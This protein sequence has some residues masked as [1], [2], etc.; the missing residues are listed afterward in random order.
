MSVLCYT[1]HAQYIQTPFTYL[2]FDDHPAIDWV[3]EIYEPDLIN[4]L[5]YTGSNHIATSLNKDILLHD[6]SYISVINGN[7]L[8]KLGNEDQVSIESRSIHTGKVNWRKVFSIREYFNIRV[9]HTF[10]IKEDTLFVLFGESLEHYSE[11]GVPFSYGMNKGELVLYKMDVYT[12]DIIERKL[13]DTGEYNPAGNIGANYSEWMINNDFQSLTLNTLFFRSNKLE[14]FVFDESPTYEVV[15]SLVSQYE[16][17]NISRGLLFYQIIEESDSS[18]LTIL[19]TPY[20]DIN[21]HVIQRYVDLKFKEE[22]LVHQTSPEDQDD[23]LFFSNR[24]MKSDSDKFGIFELRNS[25]SLEYHIFKDNQL[26]KLSIREEDIYSQVY[27]DIVDDGYLCLKTKQYYA[28]DHSIITFHKT[29]DGRDS[30]SLFSLT[31]NSTDYILAII[32]HYVL[33]DN[34]VLL[35]IAYSRGYDPYNQ[36]YAWLK[37]NGAYLN[38]KLSE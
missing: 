15:D 37:L 1:A 4:G 9:M 7:L 16:V 23:G 27:I 18:H 35:Y 6:S 33:P 17:P 12:G 21:R 13:F 14:K 31:A 30:D 10:E 19:H 2:S 22:F 24:Y 20:S 29:Q 38:E 28:D 34:S 26:K 36:Q 5:T 3:Q 25:D 11:N 8:K 32:N